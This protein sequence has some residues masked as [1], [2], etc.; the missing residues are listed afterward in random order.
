MTETQTPLRER[1]GDFMDYLEE[2]QAGLQPLPLA[3]GGT[4]PVRVGIG[5]GRVKNGPQ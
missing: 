4:A 1:A 3:E 2:W 5:S